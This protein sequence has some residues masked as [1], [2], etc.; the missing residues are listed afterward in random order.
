MS[1]RKFTALGT[2]SQVPTRRRNHGGYFLHWDDEGIL[3]DPGEG[4]QRQLI[5][6]GISVTEITKII[7]SKSLMSTLT[8][9][10]RKEI[11]DEAIEVVTMDGLTTVTT[12]STWLGI[13][14]VAMYLCGAGKVNAGEIDVTAATGGSMMAQLPALGGVTQQCIFHIPRNHNFIMEWLRINALK[15]SAAD[16]LVTIKVWV[17]STVNNGNQEVYRVDIDTSLTNNISESPQLPFPITESS[18]VWVEATTDKNNTIVN[19]R[20]SGI[21]ERMV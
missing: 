17:F 16:P 11:R 20:F 19:A 3:F 14:R 9:K 13:N 10:G 21:L 15:Q 2:A 5:F 8:K 6:A 4:T 1:N 7:N 18:V 12:T